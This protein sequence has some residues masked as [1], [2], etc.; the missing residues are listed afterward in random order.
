MLVHVSGGDRVVYVRP[1]PEQVCPVCEQ[2]CPFTLI[3]KYTH[4]DFYFIFSFVSYR[5]YFIACDYCGRGEEAD[6]HEVEATLDQIP[7]PFR[8]RYGI[9]FLPLLP[10]IALIL[11]IILSFMLD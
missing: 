9:W 4:V 5:Q 8:T 1:E 7:I 3:L 11:T 10:V 2:V 6:R